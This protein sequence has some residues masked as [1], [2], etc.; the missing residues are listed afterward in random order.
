M[1]NEGTLR[2]WRRS[3]RSCEFLCSTTGSGRERFFAATR[4]GV[5]WASPSSRQRRNRHAGGC[6]PR[7]EREGR[8][9]AEAVPPRGCAVLR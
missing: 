2:D 9:P 4:F 3:T 8:Y 7:Q 1:P 5:V 6:G